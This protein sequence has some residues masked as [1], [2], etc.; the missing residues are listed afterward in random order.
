MRK[1][2]SKKS[3]KT[4]SKN[5]LTEGSILKSLLTL[6]IPIVLATMLQTAYQ[7]IDAF[8]VGRLGEAAVA[9]V[10]LSFP[11]MFLLF[12]FGGG[13]AIAGTILVAQYRGKGNQ[14]QV[15]YF[16]AQTVLMMLA[17]SVVLTILGYF[18]TPF[19]IR[20]MGAAPDVFPQAV[21]FLQISFLGMVAV[22]GSFVFQSLMR[23]VGDVKTPLLI[24]LGS[25]ILNFFLDPLFI[26][27][28]GSFP[29]FGVGGA[30]VATVITEGLA[31]IIGFSMLFSGK[32]GIHVKLSN[33]KPRFDVVKKMF[34]LGF[35]S[36]ID[37]SLRALGFIAMVVLVASFGTTAIA[38]YGI[39]MR[40]LGFIIIPALG[41]SIATSTLVGQN[42]GAGKIARAEKIATLSTLL[43]FGA[44]TVIGILIFI[45][46]R[47]LSTFFIPG[48]EQVIALSTSFIHIIALT[49]G[50]ISIHIVLSGVFRGAGDTMTPLVL[51]L[52]SLWLIQFPLAYVLS[53]YTA[54]GVAGIWWAFPLA[55]IINAVITI[56]WYLRG[57]WK[58]KRITED[59]KMIEKVEEAALTE[60]GI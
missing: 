55:N 13:L 22:F 39:G 3:S 10:A 51:A 29:A 60:E 5:V 47:P 9:A 42:M 8:W 16:A 37:Q 56:L 17:V 2:P 7:L 40:I 49:F 14:Q 48:E 6:A 28:Y 50:L 32:Y 36:S 19:L 52:I 38:A 35:P 44:L 27:G 21:S 43:G 26:Y 46:A 25:V 53:T 34:L 24:I 12:S 23:G 30:A 18:M 58:K 1:K 45:F 20:L 41:L 33:L 31:A 59:F 54:L 11:I 15:D 57:S 4:A